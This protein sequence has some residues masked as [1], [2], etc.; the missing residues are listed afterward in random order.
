GCP[1]S[2]GTAR[3]LQHRGVLLLRPL[4]T[5]RCKGHSPAASSKPRAPAAGS[6]PTA[7]KANRPY[8]PFQ[9]FCSST[10]TTPKKLDR[11]TSPGSKSEIKAKQ[12]GAFGQQIVASRL[13][14]GPTGCLHCGDEPKRPEGL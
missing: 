11:H 7:A 13:W 5:P 3:A 9:G 12:P 8:T 14:R 10:V 2:R 6:N 1:P 4:A